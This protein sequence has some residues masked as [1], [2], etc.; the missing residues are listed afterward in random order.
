MRSQVALLLF[1]MFFIA[2]HIQSA[3]G[4]K[5]YSCEGSDCSKTKE[6]G[7]LE[8]RCYSATGKAEGQTVSI[9]ACVN[10]ASCTVDGIKR[11]F[12][13]KTC[14][15]AELCLSGSLNLGSVRVTNNANCCRTDLCNSGTLPAQ[16]AN[17]KKCFTCDNNDCSRTVNCEGNEDCCITATVQQGS[18]N[19]FMKGCA[20]KNVC[21]VAKLP[22]QPG[23]TLGQ[24]TCCEGNLCNRAGTFTLS[25]MI[26]LVPLLSSIYSLYCS[27]Q[28]L[29]CYECTTFL[30]GACSS[31]TV[32][33]CMNQCASVTTTANSYGIKTDVVLKTC[34][35]PAVCTTGSMNLGI[36]KVTSNANCC[37]TELCNTNAP[38]ALKQSVN[39]RRCYTCDAFGCSKTVNCE[40]NEDQCITTTVQQG[41]NKISMKGCATKNICEVAKYSAQF[42]TG[43]LTCCEGNLCNGAGTFTLSFLILVVPLLSTILLH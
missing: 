36:V 4:L 26:M 30:N 25:F 38:P 15:M 2:A 10:E 21:D 14:G 41:S 37:N 19:V 43:Q 5:C 13:L 23:F 18:N 12:V 17:G 1:C 35:S 34:G 32:S 31:D 22:T 6:C 27:A 9:K 16:S 24:V 42:T 40:G 33:T 7:T 39:G 11:N 8:N 20:T 29:K 3:S 28:S